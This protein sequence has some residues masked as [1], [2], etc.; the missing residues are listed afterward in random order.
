MQC[1]YF[2]KTRNVVALWA[3]HYEGCNSADEAF[4]DAI[5][6]FYPIPAIR[7]DKGCPHMMTEAE[8]DESSRLT[9]APYDL[10]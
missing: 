5:R 8:S 3:A 10:P 7:Y 6:L 1:F 2:A 4:Y 9:G